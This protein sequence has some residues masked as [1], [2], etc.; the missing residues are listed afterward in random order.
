MSLYVESYEYAKVHGGSVQEFLVDLI[1]LNVI[2]K[3][4]DFS[5]GFDETQYCEGGAFLTARF[6]QSV[7]CI[8]VLLCVSFGTNQ[9]DGEWVHGSFRGEKVC[10][11]CIPVQ[12]KSGRQSRGLEGLLLIEAWQRV[13]PSAKI[14]LSLEF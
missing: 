6:L 10:G 2:Q 3:R 9:F 11:S 7:R 14:C 1:I 8:F 12:G 4:M 13:D 5:H